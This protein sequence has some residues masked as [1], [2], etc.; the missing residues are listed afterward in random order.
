[1]SNSWVRDYDKKIDREDA[2]DS[3]IALA[4]SN[5]RLLSTEQKAEYLSLLEENL[6][7][8]SDDYCRCPCCNCVVHKDDMAL[9]SI[10]VG[11]DEYEAEE[12]FCS[13]CREFLK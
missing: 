13:D 7:E 10:K 1:M 9:A 6:L 8:D 5:K 4:C 11:W 2:I 3:A 12:K